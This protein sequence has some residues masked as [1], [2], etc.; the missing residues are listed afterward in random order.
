MKKLQVQER[1]VEE[2]KL[3][4]KPF[5]Q[6]REVTKEEYKDI[7][8]KAVQKVGVCGRGRR[9]EAASVF[10]RRELRCSGK[11]SMGVGE[12]T[13]Q[14]PRPL[15]SGR[16]T[17]GTDAPLPQVGEPE[18]EGGFRAQ[19]VGAKSGAHGHTW[20]VWPGAG[21]S[22]GLRGGPGRGMCLAWCLSPLEGYLGHVC[23]SPH[24]PRYATARAGRST[25]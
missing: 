11:G 19:G 2:V 10:L 9:S 14:R 15:L 5:Y 18:P 12:G 8:R 13:G 1:A 20:R 23:P 22:A 3:A 16:E 17:G 7:L 21:P 4:I 6:K 24:A 25:P